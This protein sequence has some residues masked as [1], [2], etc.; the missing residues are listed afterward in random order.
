M[1]GNNFGNWNQ[2]ESQPQYLVGH[3][4]SPRKKIEKIKKKVSKFGT[5][6]ALDRDSSLSFS[7]AHSFLHQDIINMEALRD[8]VS[9]RLHLSSPATPL[10][11][12]HLAEHTAIHAPVNNT[13]EWKAALATTRVPSTPHVLTKTLVFK[14][15]VA[16]SQQA[17]LIMVVALD[18]TAT[19][20]GHVAKS[21]GEK[22][23]RLAA[24]DIVKETLA[25]AVEQ[26]SPHLYNFILP[27][28]D[29]GLVSPLAVTKENAG[30]VQ[31]LLD[32]KAV[33]ASELLAFRPSNETVTV[34]M[35]ASQLQHYLAST[36]VKVTEVEFPLGG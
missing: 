22:E 28:T 5:H 6:T 14:P 27:R 36:G 26:G 24:A 35:T 15:K 8:Q 25:V 13:A 31:V 7:P 33:K 23:A 30:F 4:H 10:I 9:E 32:S 20:A 29:F 34:F 21:A 11:P 2:S 17:V 1:G 12:I 18:S 16:K 19:S 3:F